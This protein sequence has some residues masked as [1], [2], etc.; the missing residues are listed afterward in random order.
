MTASRS[1]KNQRPGEGGNLPEPVSTHNP[2][3][4]QEMDADTHTPT[5]FAD[6]RLEALDTMG[7]ARMFARLIAMAS[8]SLTGD[9]RDAVAQAAFAV[10]NLLEQA[11]DMLGGG[12]KGGEA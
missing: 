2:A 3:E 6:A 10:V 7:R 12:L 11:R 8:E 5:A 9:E 1:P 4:D